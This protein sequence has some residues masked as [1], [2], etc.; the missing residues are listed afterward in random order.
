[1]SDRRRRTDYVLAE[2]SRRL[3]LRRR[4]LDE[5]HDPT[6]LKIVVRFDKAGRVRGSSCSIESSS[7][8]EE[9]VT[10]TG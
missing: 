6:A 4:E 2:L 5:M 1:M 8:H 9:G 7:D 3:E 10:R